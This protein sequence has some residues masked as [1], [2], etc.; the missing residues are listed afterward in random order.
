MWAGSEVL[1]LF[2]SCRWCL[3]Q[4][5]CLTKNL[6]DFLTFFPP[7]EWCL[8]SLACL[9]YLFPSDCI[10]F[11]LISLSLL[12][13]EWGNSLLMW[14]FCCHVM[15]LILIIRALKS[16]L[17]DVRLPTLTLLKL[18]GKVI[19]TFSAFL[20]CHILNEFLAGSILCDISYLL[21]SYLLIATF[22]T[23]TFK[24]IIDIWIQNW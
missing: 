5:F 21:H 15:L 11:K 3:P 20:H 8:S 22:R 12:F 17:S 1:S 9:C 19:F 23:L 10:D 18:G 16:A 6:S 24:V 14:N 2:H 13:W 4:F 7:K